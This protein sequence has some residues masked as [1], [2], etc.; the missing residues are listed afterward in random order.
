MSVEAKATECQEK[1]ESKVSNVGKGKYGRI[2]RMCRTPTLDEYKKTMVIV[3]AGILILGVVGF[4]IY[5]LMSY[6]PGYF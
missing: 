1:L 5:W 2:L 6:L 4:G 3:T